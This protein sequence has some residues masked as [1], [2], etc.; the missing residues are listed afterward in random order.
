MPFKSSF[1]QL[2]TSTQF[3][4]FGRRFGR[5]GFESAAVTSNGIFSGF[6]ASGKSWHF[7]THIFSIEICNLQCKCKLTLS[8]FTHSL[9]HSSFQSYFIAKTLERIVCTHTHTH[10]LASLQI[11]STFILY[12][13]HMVFLYIRDSLLL[14]TIL[15]SYDT[16]PNSDEPTQDVAYNPALNLG[17]RVTSWQVQTVVPGYEITK[18]LPYM[19]QEFT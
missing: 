12:V 5:S 8:L 6:P 9:I 7:Y 15:S 2:I 16:Y 1:G 14:H 19:V 17:G 3:C 18:F 10:T 11:K 13:H 4:I